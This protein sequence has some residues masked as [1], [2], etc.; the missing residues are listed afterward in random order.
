[1]VSLGL[2]S[3]NKYSN[4]TRSYCMNSYSD[5][6]QGSFLDI[7]EIKLRIKQKFI[8]GVFSG[9]FLGFLPRSLWRLF[10]WISCRDFFQ[11]FYR[12]LLKY[13]SE[14]SSGNSF[15]HTIRYSCGS[16]FIY[17]FGILSGIIFGIDIVFFS[18]FV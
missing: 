18:G 12:N 11:G 7:F 3:K 2:S 13:S 9:F 8:P 6:F 1:M 17:F 4:S 16:C 10:F 14:I 15:R 5:Y